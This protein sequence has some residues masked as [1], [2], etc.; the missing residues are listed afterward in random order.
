MITDTGGSIIPHIFPDRLRAL[1]A[2]IADI[3]AAYFF[4]S[5]A[6]GEEAVND[7]DILVLLQPD[8]RVE[9]VLPSL[10]AR[11]ADGLGL[12]HDR[13]DLLPFDLN[14]ADPRVLY[15]AV[16]EGILVKEE[17]TN[18]LTDRIEELSLYFLQNETILARAER[19]QE[20]W[21]REIGQ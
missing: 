1:L 16:N 17:D 2:G 11:I 3:S 9:C 8:L 13:V 7:V 20:E 5:A 21:L 14:W 12:P 6:R 18:Y 15:R 19:L 10:T 4:G